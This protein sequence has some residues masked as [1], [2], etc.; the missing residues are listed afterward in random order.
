MHKKEKEDAMS[1]YI[2]LINKP[3]I[4]TG[5]EYTFKRASCAHSSENQTMGGSLGAPLECVVLLV[6]EAINS[7]KVI[8]AC[9][10]LAVSSMHFMGLKQC[11][12]GLC[13]TRSASW[14]LFCKLG[15]ND[16]SRRLMIYDFTPN[17]LEA[18]FE[19]FECSLAVI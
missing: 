13:Y 9:L 16:V 14:S 11:R 15:Y 17:R 6:C 18:S 19:M 12:H 2:K 10:D 8:A 1:S 3:D 5:L 7:W 4:T